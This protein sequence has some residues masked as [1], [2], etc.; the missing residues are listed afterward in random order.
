MIY[1]RRFTT[2]ERGTP[3]LLF[4]DGDFICFTLEDPIRP[5]KIYG[6]TCIAAGTYPLRKIQHGRFYEIYHKRWDH[7]FAIEIAD[8]EQFTNIR[9]HSGV[10]KKDT[11]GCPLTG[12]GFNVDAMALSQSRA[13]YVKLYEWL[14]SMDPLP[15]L[16]ITDPP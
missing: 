12:L 4:H 8:V 2:N 14:E 6:D 1:L 15:S 7:K 9:I 13:A 11:K 10:T 16:T 3:G 5:E